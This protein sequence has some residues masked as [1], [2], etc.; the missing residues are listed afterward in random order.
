MKINRRSILAGLAGFLAAPKAG[1]PAKGSEVPVYTDWIVG[2]AMTVELPVNR[3]EPADFSFGTTKAADDI[4]RL[5]MNVSVNEFDCAIRD[6]SYALNRASGRHIG[7]VWAGY[8]ESC[9]GTEK[10]T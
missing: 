9:E 8:T 5:T 3:T 2:E 6:V 7:I 10:I 1:A 4:Q